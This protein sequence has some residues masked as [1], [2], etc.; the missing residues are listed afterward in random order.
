[1]STPPTTPRT[2]ARIRP[3]TAALAGLVLLAA[4]ALPAPAAIIEVFTIDN[5]V[6]QSFSYPSPL[7]GSG[8]VVRP[9]QM[10]RFRAVLKP[11]P[12]QTQA[13]VLAITTVPHLISNFEMSRSTSGQSVSITRNVTIGNDSKE[14]KVTLNLDSSLA[15]GYHHEVDSLDVIVS[16]E[17]PDPGYLVRFL[18]MEVDDR[19]MRIPT[20]VFVTVEVQSVARASY[21]QFNVPGTEHQNRGITTASRSPRATLA[22]AAKDM[23]SGFTDGERIEV[24]ARAC[25]ARGCTDWRSGF[26]EFGR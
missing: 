8:I 26:V 3:L 9:G 21:Y 19:N 16:P 23:R 22:V 2:S 17:P 20:N 6:K 10:A 15:V 12:G 24:R 7:R 25:N 13:K 4:A 5:P 11:I 14:R 1:M 18:D